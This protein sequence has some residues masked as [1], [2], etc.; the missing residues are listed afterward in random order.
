MSGKTKVDGTWKNISAPYIKVSGVWKIAK[1]AYIKIAG[2][3]KTWFLQ[4]G[5]LDTPFAEAISSYVYNNFPEYGAIG[6]QSTGKIIVG[7]SFVITSP[8]YNAHIARFNS[9]GTLD[10]TFN[11]TGISPLIKAIHVL[12]DDSLL[13]GNNAGFGPILFKSN[14]NNVIDNSFRDNL[15][16]GFSGGSSIT[17]SFPAVFS[18]KTTATNK[19]LVGG[20]F[21]GLNGAS[22]GHFIQLN[23][24]GTVDSTF[25]TALGTAANDYVKAIVVQSDGK[26][27]VG[28]GFS[29]F[30]GTSAGRLVRLN[31]DGTLDSAFM[32]NIGS[33]FNVEVESIVVQPD[34]KILVSGGWATFNGVS[35]PRILRLNSDG[36]LD[37]TFNAGG[38]WA[39]P[40][41]IIL[42]ENGSVLVYGQKNS[43]TSLSAGIH[44]LSSSGQLDT[45]F[46]Q[47]AGTGIGST[48]TAVAA[49]AV[50]Q[51]DGK[52]LIAG[53]ITSF[54]GI[55]SKHMVR[56]GGEVASS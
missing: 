12:P 26:I 39:T 28:G 48:G 22:A 24:N 56:I 6:L 20:A 3:W 41:R 46:L 23:S 18:I 5:L 27:L 32:A 50:A 55:S 31:S 14:P 17:G 4:G 40:P 15:G 9:D 44:R 21:T 36:T 10:Q 16:S 37:G 8:S 51:A 35:R 33:G 29:S 42:L 30:N 25:K 2:T 53:R 45:A 54:N 11:G 13:I 47:N 49:H 52:I 43:G 34:N 19:I 1:A 38:S 7:G